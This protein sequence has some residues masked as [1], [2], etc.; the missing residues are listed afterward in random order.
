MTTCL[1][2]LPELLRPAWKQSGWMQAEQQANG[3][4][5]QPLAAVK[6]LLGAGQSLDQVMDLLGKMLHPKPAA[7]ISVPDAL[8]HPFLAA[9]L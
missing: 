5:G 9:Q 6:D 7:R 1:L 3:Q 8:Q 2:W 4:L